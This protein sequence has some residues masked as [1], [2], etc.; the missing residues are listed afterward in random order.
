MD[1]F[2][3]D[4]SK[5]TKPNRP[6]YV[7]SSKVYILFGSIIIATFFHFSLNILEHLHILFGI[8]QFVYEYM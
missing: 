2:G 8:E 4:F 6:N 5:P 3:L 7:G 1:Q